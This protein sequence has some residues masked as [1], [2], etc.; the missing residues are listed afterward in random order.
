[1]QCNTRA[2]Y[3]TKV[4]RVR[5]QRKII[6]V[7]RKG[8]TLYDKNPLREMLSRV[9]PHSYI[10]LEQH[11]HFTREKIKETKNSYSSIYPFL[12]YASLCGDPKGDGG[13]PRVLNPSCPCR[14][15][16]SFLILYKRERVICL[17]ARNSKPF[18]RRV[19]VMMG[20]W[21]F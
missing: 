5:V 10:L 20:C 17:Q 4:R 2:S 19:V 15:H 11:R 1:M 8:I 7:L 14:Y 18:A 9:S 21:E 16:F 6:Q 12:D 3:N 13:L